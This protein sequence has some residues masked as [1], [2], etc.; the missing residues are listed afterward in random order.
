M[1]FLQFQLHYQNH[2]FVNNFDNF[3]KA[4]REKQFWESFRFRDWNKRVTTCLHLQV[5]IVLIARQVDKQKGK[6]KLCQ[7]CSRA[8][9]F[10]TVCQP[11][12]VPHTLCWFFF[13]SIWVKW[14]YKR[15]RA[16]IILNYK[17]KFWMSIYTQKNRAS[18]CKTLYPQHLLAPKYGQVYTVPYFHTKKWTLQKS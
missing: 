18:V 12:H 15:W 8:S 3:K 14:A 2:T 4:T 9:A 7:A 6:L 17:K 5:Y 16:G 13:S 10:Q 11:L 1:H